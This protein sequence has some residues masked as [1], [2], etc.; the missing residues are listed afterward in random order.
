[1]L[2]QLHHVTRVLQRLKSP[3]NHVA[4]RGVPD[5]AR[6]YRKDINRVFEGGCI[7]DLG[8]YNALLALRGG[9]D[10]A[11]P[12]PRLSL[13][14][15]QIEGPAVP[16]TARSRTGCG[17]SCSSSRR[18]RRRRPRRLSRPRQLRL[19]GVFM[20]QRD[21]QVVLRHAFNFIESVG[22]A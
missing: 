13:V 11:L 21:V 4:R 8:D 17:S 20:E 15:G 22:H 18:R 6:T 7:V 12:N 10:S 5:A 14:P 16:A 19:Q 1:M 3:A 9:A 2:E